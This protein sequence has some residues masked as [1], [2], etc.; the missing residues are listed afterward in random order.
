V[1]FGKPIADQGVTRERIANA[2]ILID[3]AAF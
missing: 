1:A 3:Q 2:R